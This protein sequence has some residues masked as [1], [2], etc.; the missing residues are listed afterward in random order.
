M[1]R[2]NQDCIS[3]HTNNVYLDSLAEGIHDQEVSHYASDAHSQNDRADGVVS[4]VWNI[5]CGESISD[6]P[7]HCH[8]CTAKKKARR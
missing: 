8:L 1:S 4:V 7:H 5:H 2:S 3:Y 6:I